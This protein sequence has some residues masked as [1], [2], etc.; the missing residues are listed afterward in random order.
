MSGYG[1]QESNAVD[2][3]EVTEY[4]GILAPVKDALGGIW[5]YDR[6]HILDLV[7]DCFAL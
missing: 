5:Y 3:Y 4:G 2:V 1:F 6:L 7:K